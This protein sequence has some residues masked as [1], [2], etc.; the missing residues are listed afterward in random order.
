MSEEKKYVLFTPVGGNDPIGNEYDKD[1]MI[2]EINKKLENCNIDEKEKLKELKEDIIELQVKEEPVII[3]GP[4][5][6]IVRH[7]K[8]KC[9]LLLFTQSDKYLDCKFRMMK[10]EI[11]KLS[12]NCI[13]RK[14]THI[15]ASYSTNWNEAIYDFNDKIKKLLNGFEDHEILVNIT[16]GSPQ[17]S[18]KLCNEIINNNKLKGIQVSVSLR[19]LQTQGRKD[20]YYIDNNIRYINE[21]Y[22][23]NISRCIEPKIYSVIKPKLKS[24]IEALVSS[25]K[26]YNYQALYRLLNGSKNACDELFTNELFENASKANDRINL[27]YEHKDEAS[28][29]IEY[30]F[31][32]KVK[33]IKGELS[34]FFLRIT[35]FITEL[36]YYYFS[37]TLNN[38][39]DIL[40]ENSGVKHVDYFNNIQLM[41]K[42]YFDEINYFLSKQTNNKIKKIYQNLNGKKFDKDKKYILGI[43]SNFFKEVN[44]MYEN[45]KL[46]YKNLNNELENFKKVSDIYKKE[47]DVKITIDNV[48]ELEHL[49]K[50]DYTN[51]ESIEK[52]L[53]ELKNKNDSEE[54][55]KIYNKAKSCYDVYIWFKIYNKL[56]RTGYITLK[57]LIY[58]NDNIKNNSDINIINLFRDFIKIEDARHQIAHYLKNITEND[59]ANIDASLSSES[60]LKK[61]ERLLYLIFYKDYPFYF[62]NKDNLIFDYDSVN[63]NILKCIK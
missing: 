34:D 11:R 50:S 62:D 8:P 60:I 58:I 21:K 46:E 30:Y 53:S 20:K 27:I 18:F 61:C 33:Q 6:H 59:I 41:D 31:A 14:I 3:E 57:R 38:S 22:E 25:N 56:K 23:N 15:N 44:K 5:L 55:K 2:E 40:S 4:I 17:I 39:F 37:K 32:M 24:Q 45:F 9:V 49:K 16:S 48:L 52:E 29:F 12:S 7:Y 63:E 42:E 28:P 10:R 36:L 1:Y 54:L 26:L 51:I 19:E 35:P 47:K 13:I 43:M